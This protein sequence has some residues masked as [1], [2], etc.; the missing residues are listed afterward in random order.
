MTGELGYSLPPAIRRIATNFR[1]TGW[2][3]FWA[4]IV[5]G[6]ISSLMFAIYLIRPAQTNVDQVGVGF[7]ILPALAAVFIG[8]F[9]AFRYVRF[10]KKLSTS[11]PDLRPKPK[12]AARI[13]QIGLLISIVGMALS[14]M[15]AET[16]VALLFERTLSQPPVV[17]GAPN[18]TTLIITTGDLLPVFSV[19]NAMFTHFIGLCGSLWLQYVV[20]R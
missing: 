18:S 14:I 12:D 13:V 16:A 15:G 7:F 2:V 10:G 5:V 11:N 17:T 1:L 8:A 19:V 4:Q 20:N 3:S 9:W 6:V